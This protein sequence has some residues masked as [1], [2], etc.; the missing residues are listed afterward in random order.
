MKAYAVE[1]Q[2]DNAVKMLHRFGNRNA[3]GIIT[4][5]ANAATTKM[6]ERY[7]G[8]HPF[9]RVGFK[10]HVTVIEREY[11]ERDEVLP[12]RCWH[13]ARIPTHRVFWN[14]R[15]RHEARRAH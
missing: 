2:R 11:E 6:R 12:R 13:H 5:A 8:F 14:V 9:S 3:H 4:A 7:P 15:E 10:F 1:A